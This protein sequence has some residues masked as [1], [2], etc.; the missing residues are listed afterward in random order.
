MGFIVGTAV[1][2]GADGMDDEFGG[3]VVGFSDA[4]LSGGAADAG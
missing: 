2:D 3:E 1:P 4:G